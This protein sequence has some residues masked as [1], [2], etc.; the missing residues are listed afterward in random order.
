MLKHV[1]FALSVGFGVVALSQG[2]VGP[3]GAHASLHAAAQAAQAPHDHAAAPASPAGQSSQPGMNGMHQKMMAD[4]KAADEK[5]SALLATMNTAQG[6][7]KVTAIAQVVNELV[8][9]QKA[10]HEHMGMMEMMM[11]GGGM[12]KK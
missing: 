9:Q 12:M 3:A 4:M 1:M 11:G 5:L 2:W 10:M 8:L 6:D 7:A